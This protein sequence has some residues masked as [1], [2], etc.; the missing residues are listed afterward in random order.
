MVLDKCIRLRQQEGPDIWWKKGRVGGFKKMYK[1][2]IACS[3]NNNSN[4][5]TSCQCLQYA[6]DS[7][8][9][10]IFGGRKEE[11]V[12]STECISLTLFVV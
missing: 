5:D 6:V 12:V 1:T 10:L 8:R 7:R 11:L 2:D 9:V 4:S 3:I